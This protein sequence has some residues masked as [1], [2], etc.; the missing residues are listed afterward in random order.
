MSDSNFNI[1]TPEFLNTLKCSGVPDHELN[2]K[3]GTP[4]MLLRN[5]DHSRELCNSTR[6]DITRLTDR[7]IEG[8]VLT[9]SSS[10]ELG[11]IPRLS[12]TLSDPRLPF[13]FQR[14]QFPLIVSYAMSINKSQGQSFAHVGVFLKK[15]IFNH[16]QLYVAVSRTSNRSGLKIMLCH[17]DNIDDNKIRE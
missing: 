9:S 4:V 7:L 10:G 16:G 12:L 11:L 6:L 3:V 17:G 2:L 13:K 5:I 8:K 14:R 15:P 1:H